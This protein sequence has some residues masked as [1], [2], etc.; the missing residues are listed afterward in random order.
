VDS[1]FG[2]AKFPSDSTAIV[3]SEWPTG[4]ATAIWRC[5][6]HVGASVEDALRLSPHAVLTV[7]PLTAIDH[8]DYY[9]D[10]PS[11]DSPPG[12]RPSLRLVH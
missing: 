2:G 12:D 6:N 1:D 8:T 5:H 10:E 4:Y 11:P 7:T 3:A 9:T